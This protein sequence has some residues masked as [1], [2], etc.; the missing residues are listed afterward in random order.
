MNSCNPDFKLIMKYL[1]KFEVPISPASQHLSKK[2][3]THAKRCF[4]KNEV[5]G[6][7]YTKFKLFEDVDEKM[8]N[9]K[10]T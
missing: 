7:R 6:W 9:F 5:I 1:G 2:I 10:C 4:L 3:G 8:K